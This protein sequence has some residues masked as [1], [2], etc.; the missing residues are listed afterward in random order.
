[1]KVSIV[2]ISFNQAA[3][4]E[5][6]IKSV[7]EQDYDDIEYIVVDPGSTDGS[8][9]IIEKYRDKITTV[10][11]DPDDG[12]VDG[13][14]NGFAAATG[15]IYAYL[16]ADD[17]LLKGAVSKAV[18]YFKRLSDV[19]VIT[20]HGYMVDADGNVIRRFYSDSFTP[21]RYVHGGCVVMQQSTFFKSD[22]FKEVGGFNLGNRIWWDGELILDFALAGK[23]F[24]VVKDFMSIFRI[25]DDSIS[26]SRHGQT[27]ASIRNERLRQENLDRFYIKVMGHPANGFTPIATALAR[28]IKWMLA[29]FNT[30]WRLL[31]KLGF[32]FDKNVRW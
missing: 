4:L 1:M 31:E 16:N 25:H 26:G 6:A 32:R 2:T 12:P 7:V 8:R 24:I 3:F 20:G 10:I 14:N 23:K 19:D 5:T 30:F 28:I 13:L 15:D 9:E 17:A 27:E 22:A 18:A 29:P 11:L 21:W